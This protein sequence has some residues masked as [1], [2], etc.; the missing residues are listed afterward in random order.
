MPGSSFR[1]EP[2]GRSRPGSKV[3]VLHFISDSYPTE[4]FRLIARYTDHERITMQ[5]ASLHSAGGLQDG[6][7]EIGIPTFAMD[8]D[9][10]SRYPGT[11]L[12]LARVLHRSQIDVLHV[13]LFDASLVGLLAARLARTPLRVFAGHHS[14][15]VPLYKR[16]A[17]FEVDRFAARTLADVAVA[18]SGQMR[19]IFVSV[20]GLDPADVAV[21][22]H[23]LDL[24]RFNPHN[25]NR[26]AVRSELN[27]DGKLVLGS[28]SK[29]HWVKNLDALVRGFS[30]LA[31]SNP[32]VQL[33]ILGVGDSSPVRH[34][35]DQ[36]GL[37]QRVNVLPYR[38]DV[39]DFLA[40]LDVFIHPALAESFGFAIAEA[41][42]MAKPVVST[43]VGIA[44][45]VIEDGVS[46]IEI[47]GTDPESLTNAMARAIAWRERWPALGEE[48]RRRVLPFTAERWVR[49]H[50]EL[51]ARRLSRD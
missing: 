7:Q 20:Y 25:A 5:V 47:S 13:H 22:E 38:E 3:R 39:P 15:E 8:A 51:Y 36:L 44:P 34:L 1:L 9:R 24:Q 6:L 27:L 30:A 45:D 21:I 12:R 19:D 17:L 50:E 10:R 46:G 35:V 14:H 2:G 4:Y 33:V 42:A 43:R 32:D 31:K 16:R 41:M 23:G 18:P 26:D 40:A 11:V 37:G 49:R 28:I 29:H 48:A